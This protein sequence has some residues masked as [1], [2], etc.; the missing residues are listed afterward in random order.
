MGGCFTG[1]T[2][3]PSAMLDS[4]DL[5]ARIAKAEYK[6]R[7]P[8]L[9]NRL[10]DLHRACW[11]EG[12]AAIVLFEGW[13]ASGT[14]EVIN[15]L[16]QR[17]E[18]RG[19]QLHVLREPR[20]HELP[21]PWLWRFQLLVPS[22]GELGIFDRSWY[23]QLISDRVEG[24]ID[25]VTGAARLEDVRRFERLLTEDRYLL[26]KIFLHISEEEKGRR[27]GRLQKGELTRWRVTEEML[28]AHERYVAYH[29]DIST[30]LEATDRPR[31]RWSVVPATNRRLARIRVLEVLTEQLERG[32]E[33]HGIDPQALDSGEDAPAD[34]SQPAPAE[35]RS[36]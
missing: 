16:T 6:R 15:K 36:C 10:F 20:T 11:K 4:V 12:L 34:E 33:R 5:E 1:S 35:V 3:H 18:P 7:L 24:R 27:L 22:Y 8:A 32:L 9:R 21:M 17:L 30:I 14:G 29:K 31:R 2:S 26:I 13:D 19:F 25:E 28:A 23:R